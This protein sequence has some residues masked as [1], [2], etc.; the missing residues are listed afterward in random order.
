MG[1]LAEASSRPGMLLAADE[2]QYCPHL[3]LTHHLKSHAWEA[4][5]LSRRPLVA[6]RIALHAAAPRM[7]QHSVHSLCR[8]ALRAAETAAADAL[9]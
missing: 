9:F 1:F 8:A 3:L 2:H 6:S 5:G 4:V 7:L